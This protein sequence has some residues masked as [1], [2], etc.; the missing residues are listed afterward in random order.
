MLGVIFLSVSLRSE[1]LHN[2]MALFIRAPMFY[3]HVLVDFL[4]G[5]IQNVEAED[6]G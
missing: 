4:K 6:R 5:L 2:M 1:T 3:M